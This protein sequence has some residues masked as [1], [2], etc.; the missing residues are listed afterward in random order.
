MLFLSSYHSAEE[1]LPCLVASRLD[2]YYNIICP[3]ISK[4][5]SED[6]ACKMYVCL[7]TMM[8]L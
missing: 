5:V 6:P 4:G 3:Y 7:F 8:Y 2:P 1:D